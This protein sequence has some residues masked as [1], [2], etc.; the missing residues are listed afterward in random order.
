[1]TEQKYE[2]LMKDFFFQKEKKGWPAQGK[3]SIEQKGDAN[4]EKDRGLL[5]P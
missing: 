3:Y 2:E 1:M 5:L 4:K